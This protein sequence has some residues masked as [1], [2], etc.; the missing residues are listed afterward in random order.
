M[1]S[2]E[3]IKDELKLWIQYVVSKVS[4]ESRE[5]VTNEDINSVLIDILHE[6]N[7][8]D[9]KEKYKV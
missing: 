8:Q 9:P 4:E 3:K 2:K 1:S 6:N 5:A 7:K